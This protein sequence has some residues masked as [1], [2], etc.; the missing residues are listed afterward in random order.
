MNI[1]IPDSERSTRRRASRVMRRSARPRTF[2]VAFAGAG[3]VLGALLVPSAYAAT[4]THPTAQGT[5][6]GIQPPQAVTGTVPSFGPLSLTSKAP[7]P[8]K[9][10]GCYLYSSDKWASKPCL[11]SKTVM[12]QGPPPALVGKYPPGVTFAGAAGAG[13]TAVADSYVFDLGI[14]DSG[15]SE[16]DT[17]YGSNAWS[18]QDNTNV[19]TGNNGNLDWV[20]FVFQYFGSGT[21]QTCIWQVDVTVARATH[22][23]SGYDPTGCYSMSA[24]PEI[25]VGADYHDRPGSA[26][27]LAVETTTISG[28]VQASV[29][30]DIYGLQKGNRWN[31]VSGGILGAGGSSEAVFSPGWQEDEVADASD[32]ST[33]NVVPGCDQG[34]LP[35]GTVEFPSSVT[36]ESSNLTTPSTPKLTWAKGRHRAYVQYD[37]TAP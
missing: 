16:S 11:S 17:K 36:G 23:K 21:P 22:N 34:S 28:Q 25:I 6:Q 8:P 13:S 14:N 10:Q 1:A 19:F 5:A 18:V 26:A 9:K 20:Q 30:N 12:R 24:G 15:K 37:A 2:A 31:S 3:V 33:T 29:V 27:Q 4:V 32:C 35:S 7:L